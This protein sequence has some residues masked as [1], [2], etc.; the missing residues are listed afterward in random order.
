MAADASNSQLALTP[1]GAGDLI[2]RAVR[3]YRQNFWTFVWIAAPPIIVGTLIS[4]GWT[5]LGREIFSVG[6]SRNRDEMV[7]YYLFIWFG[8]MIIW[9]TETVAT[10]SVMGGASRNFVR[11]LLFGEPLSFRETY[12]N[13]WKRVFGLL[14]AS[15]IIA[16]L[17]G[18]IGAA[19][20]YFGI[21]AAVL[22]VAAAAYTLSFSPFLII[23]VSILLGGAILFGTGWLFFLV[24]S[25]FAYVQQV[26]MVEGQGV[27]SAIGRSTALASGNVK[28]F[29]ALF[30]FT[31]AAT[32]SALS[33]FYIPLGWYAYWEGVQLFSFDADALPAWYEIAKQVVWQASFILLM[34]V[35]MIGLCLLYVDE[36]V[37]HEGY[38][39]EL[40]A[41]RRLGEIP[42]VPQN[43]VNPLQPALANQQPPK[44]K[45]DSSMTTL[46]LN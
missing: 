25:R 35:W 36:R 34:P 15:M 31:T 37:R 30:L 1:L 43:F 4:I 17:L 8:T 38:D 23:L 40:L 19:I 45:K 2:D 27:F 13:V 29:A 39:I 6:A 3:F 33:L 10:L 41:A 9:L 18:F 5:F 12:R 7:F 26:M 44:Y 16:L 20:F 24:A 28:R 22:A 11:H 42:A 21:L 32:Y 46:G 14:T